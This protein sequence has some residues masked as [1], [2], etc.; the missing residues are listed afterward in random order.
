MGGL[1]T[2]P[3]CRTRNRVPAAASGVPR[4][5]SCKAP[6]P[7]LVP[8]TDVDFAQVSDTHLPVL[9]DLWAPWCGPCQV[10][11][12]VL[13]VLASDRAGKIKVAKVNVDENPR[14]A[15][16]FGALSIPTLVLV[17]D[18]VEVAR[19]VGALPAP[20]LRAWLDDALAQ[21]AG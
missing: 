17:R 10:I 14:L 13:E 16:R 8:A 15:G 7:W 5:G 1:V 2:C 6:L 9:V 12:P 21:T 19:H 20:H 4:C 11:A 18:G 3:A